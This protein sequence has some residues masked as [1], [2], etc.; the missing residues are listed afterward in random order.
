[1]VGEYLPA[2]HSWHHLL[3]LRDRDSVLQLCRCLQIIAFEF[4][5]VALAAIELAVRQVSHFR[6]VAF[7]NCTHDIRTI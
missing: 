1:M 5:L 4:F 6:L 7:D 3:I 2:S